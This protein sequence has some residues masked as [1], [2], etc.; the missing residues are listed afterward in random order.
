MK[1]E[2]EV[3]ETFS[4]DAAVYLLGHHFYSRIMQPFNVVGNRKVVLEVAVM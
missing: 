4:I 2:N 3:V 1:S